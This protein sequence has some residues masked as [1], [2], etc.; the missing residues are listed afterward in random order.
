[1]EIFGH[2]NGD[3][4]TEGVADASVVPEDEIAGDR[5]VRDADGSPSGAA[6]NDRRGDIADGGPG[7]GVRS[8]AEVRAVNF[9]FA[10]GHSCGGRD[11]FEVGSGGVAGM[12]K[13]HC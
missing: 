9:G 5:A 12:K 4:K 10:S 3:A 6:E 8:G 1:M 11:P 7:N 13:A 2:R